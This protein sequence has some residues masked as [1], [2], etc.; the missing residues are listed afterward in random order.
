MNFWLQTLFKKKAA[1]YITYKSG[2]NE[3]QIDYILYRKGFK[4]EVTDCKV[5]AGEVVAPQHRVVVCRLK[6]EVKNRSGQEIREKKLNWWKLGRY[7]K[8]FLDEVKSRCT[9]RSPAGWLG[10][11]CRCRLGSSRKGPWVVIR[12]EEEGQGDMVVV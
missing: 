3:T 5:I 4:K 8:E 6:M 9:E 1:H 2:G 12:E 11:S 7:K 10:R